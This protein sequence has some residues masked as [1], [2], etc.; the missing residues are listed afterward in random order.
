M[1]FF[2]VMTYITLVLSG[3]LIVECIMSLPK[4]NKLMINI[5]GPIYQN[6]FFNVEIFWTT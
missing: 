6:T 4:K 5:F 2:F 3:H 1:W